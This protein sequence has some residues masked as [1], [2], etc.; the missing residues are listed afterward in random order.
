MERVTEEVARALKE[1]NCDYVGMG[2]E[3]GNEPYRRATL[4]KFFSNQQA[5]EAVK[6]LQKYDIKVFTGFML[7][8]PNEN[9]EQAFESLELAQTLK[10][11]YP[12]SVIFQPYPGT[13][14]AETMVMDN[15]LS[16]NDIDRISPDLHSNSV[17]KSPEIRQIINLHR[18]FD[19]AVLYPWATPLVKQL[20]KL[21]NN[22][23]FTLFHRLIYFNLF[24]KRMKKGF[25]DAFLFAFKAQVAMLRK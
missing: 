19:F 21:P 2:I 22:I 10:P 16:T 11:E 17:V 20:I 13:E 3:T 18:F 23:L 1:S 4:K 12:W 9:L 6:L 25:I 5:V 24:R 15:T 8:L 7:G 14:I